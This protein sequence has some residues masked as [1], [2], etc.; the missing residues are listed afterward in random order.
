MRRARDA[1]AKARRAMGLTERTPPTADDYAAYRERYCNWG[2]WGDDDELGT[3]N[4]VTPTVRRTAA[5]LVVEG[6][7]VSLA[8][9]LDTHARADNPYPAHHFVAVE[10]SGG[11]VDYVG[12]FVHGFTQTH[13]D[14]LCH[15]RTA[16][17]D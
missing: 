3:L 6:R 7:T 10:G 4:L 12:C 5:S 9:P 13:I 8:R 16:E 2:R 17:G 15:L 1:D 11:M 14:A